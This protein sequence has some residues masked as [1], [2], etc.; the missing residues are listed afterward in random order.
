M[1]VPWWDSLEEESGYDNK[2]ERS[3][4][5]ASEHCRRHDGVFCQ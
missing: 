4:R 2:K 3:R 1:P 5:S